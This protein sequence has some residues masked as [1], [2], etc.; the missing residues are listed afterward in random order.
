MAA[1][2]AQQHSL[3]VPARPVPFS[4]P[5]QFGVLTA[6]ESFAE[7]DQIGVARLLG[8]DRTTTSNVVGRL[9]DRGLIKRVPDP[10]E[11][12]KMCEGDD[13]RCDSVLGD[14]EKLH[15]TYRE[16]IVYDEDQVYPAYIC[17]YEGVYGNH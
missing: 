8:M 15:G 11:L 5:A 14:R 16:L 17:H 3:Q 7:I 10:A 13:R 12:E 2:Q 9:E 4:T 1:R 6:L